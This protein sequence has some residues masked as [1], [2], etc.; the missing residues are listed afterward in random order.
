M[1]TGLVPVDLEEL[2]P[3]WWKLAMMKESFRYQDLVSTAA[4]T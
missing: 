3:R 4:G 1:G 2:R